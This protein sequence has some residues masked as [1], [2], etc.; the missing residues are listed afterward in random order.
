[1]ENTG[2]YIGAAVF[3][4]NVIE[5]KSGVLSLIRIVDRLVVSS[6]GPSAPEQMPSTPL[7]WFLVLVLKSGQA[8]GSINVTIQPELPSGLK[9]EPVTVTPH[10]EGENRGCNVVTKM[11]MMLTEPGVYWFHILIGDAL[12]TKVPLEVIYSRTVI[13]GPRRLPPQTN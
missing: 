1:M 10:F 2:P 12:A 11:A 5:D 9:L 6:Q 13:P 7:N 4:E 3:C 8:R